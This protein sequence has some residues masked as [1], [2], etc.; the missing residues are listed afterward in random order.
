MDILIRRLKDSDRD[1]LTGFFK[2]NWGGET[3]LCRE[4]EYRVG[5]LGGFVAEFEGSKVGLITYSLMKEELEIASLNSLVENRGIGTRLVKEVEKYALESGAKEIKLI[6]TNDNLNAL[7]FY[8][9]RGYR[10]SKIFSGAMDKVREIK[11]QVPLVGENGIPL[12]D[13]IE[14][15]KSLDVV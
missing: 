15:R 11:P 8:Q 10:L 3:I 2:E 5:D 4:K 6:T 9:K 13:E 12:L 7:K 14:L 1:W